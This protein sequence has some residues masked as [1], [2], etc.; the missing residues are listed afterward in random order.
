VK[1]KQYTQILD[2]V[3]RESKESISGLVA[4]SVV[5]GVANAML[6]GIINAGSTAI[7]PASP[8][9]R[10]FLI[11][12]V[13][14]ALYVLTNRTIL[15][16]SI[17]MAETMINRLRVRLSNKVRN[18][19]LLRL[20]KLG[21]A[22][23]YTRI[24]TET[25]TI[26]QAAPFIIQTLQNAVMILFC[27]L[28]IAWLSPAAFLLAVLLISGG[29][30][31]Y[32]REK[33]TIKSALQLSTQ[34]E[35]EFFS[36]L[37]N[38]LDGFKEIRLNRAKSDD[39]FGGLDRISSETRDLKIRT[40]TQFAGIATF[41]QSFFYILLGVIVFIMPRFSEINPD[42]MIRITAAILFI[43]GPL[44]AIVSSI[45]VFAMANVS[46]SNLYRLEEALGVE[47]GPGP[48]PRRPEGLRS[49]RFEGVT[50]S[51]RD[52]EGKPLFK[53]GP[54][55]LEIKGGETLF[56]VGGNGSGKSTFLKLLT[57]L[58]TADDGAIRWDGGVVGG[59]N[60]G[61]Y[62]ELFSAIF[63]DYHLFD[64]LYGLKEIDAARVQELL[65]LLEL[66]RKTSFEDGRLTHQDLSGGQKKRLALLTAYLEDKPVYVFDEWAADQDPSFRRFF[67]EEILKD[68]KRRGKTVIAAT[69]DDKYFGLADRVIKLDYG[70]ILEN[71]GPA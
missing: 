13:T 52:G 7:D 35:I 63:S 37:T 10:L 39:V 66:D 29:I 19:E 45:Q 65:A 55:D 47:N 25:Q 60:V 69:H 9:P 51:Y 70:R 5:S 38:V 53:V 18:S 27:G 31:H 54:I 61:D 56:M 30:A 8:S 32:F 49:I 71:G 21:Q 43:V 44:T 64:R 22:Q 42:Q 15:V 46:I 28:Y 23:I 33:Q 48:L 58:Y 6:L 68:F 34:R 1:T 2:L 17:E 14:L 3:R 50:F 67:Y 11:F 12:L 36:S 40:G 4:I 16:K 26:S 20:E 59:K 24:T 62:R 41:S 57:G